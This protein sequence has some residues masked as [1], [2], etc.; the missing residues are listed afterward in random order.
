MSKRTV[1]IQVA[2]SNP[3]NEYGV[4]SFP[5]KAPMVGQE[6]VHRHLETAI[7]NFQ[8]NEGSSAWF[9]VLTSTWGGGKTRTADEIVGQ[10]TGESKGWIDRTGAPLPAIVQPDFADGVL[11]V[12][13]SYK[14]AIKQVEEAGR[15]LPFTAWI[16]RVALAALIGLR[17]KASPQLKSVIEHLE[18]FKAP[19]ARAIRNLPRLADVSRSTPLMVG[20]SLDPSN[21]TGRTFS[22]EAEAVQSVI[23]AMKAN[24]LNRLLVIVE[25]VE[26]PS[27]IR[28]KPG[29][30]LG[31]EAY[32]EIKDTY[33]DVIPEVL[34]SD[35]ERQRFPNVGFLML[36]SPAVYSTIEKIPSQVRRHYAVPIG[37]NTVADLCGYLA[38]L[39]SHDSTIPAYSE[40]LI[41][42]AY[43][44]VDRNMGWM[45]VIMYSRHR[46]WVEGENDPV[47]LLREFAMAD[48]RGKEV[49]VE[50]G[51]DRITGARTDGI[52]QKLLFGQTPVALADIAP[53]DMRRLLTMKVLDATT[54]KAFVELHPLRVGLSELL[55]TALSE[56]G[57][58]VIS[59]GG[60]L[61]LAGDLKVDLARVLDDLA[62]YKTD[63]AGRPVVPRDRDQFILHVTAL[64]GISQTGAAAQ[65]L[66]P[67]FARHIAETATHFGPSFAALRQLDKRLQREDAQFRLLDEE[68]QERMLN[69][70]FAGLSGTDRLRSFVRGFLNLLEEHKSIQEN[71]A[72]DQAVTC[73]VEL[74][75]TDALLLGQDSKIWIVAGKKGSSVRD[76]LLSLGADDKPVRPILLLLSTD[77]PSQRELIDQF[78]Q[79]RPAIAERVFQFPLAEVDERL[80]FLKSESLSEAELTSLAGSLLYRLTERIKQALN[81]RFE[82]L[83]NCG[84]VVW[85]LFRSPGW[86]PYAHHLAEIWLFLAADSNHTLNDAE[87]RFGQTF[88]ENAKAAL[89]ENRPT[90]KKET[91]HLVDHDATPPTPQ[92]SSGLARLVSLMK[93]GGRSVEYLTRRF[94]GASAKPRD[95]VEQMLEWLVN[96]GLVV[97]ASG[98]SSVRIPT[99]SEVENAAEAARTWHDNDLVR[100]LEDLSRYTGIQQELK[101]GGDELKAKLNDLIKTKRLETF[102]TMGD[103][104]AIAPDDGS[105]RADSLRPCWSALGTY[106][107]FQHREMATN[108]AA[109]GEALAADAQQL[110]EHIRN[111]DIPF[112]DR[113]DALG[114][115]VKKL[116]TRVTLL[117]SQIG[118]AKGEYKAKLDAAGLPSLVFDTP[119]D[120]L[121][122]LT[123]REQG[124]SK[125]TKGIM[126][127]E[128]LIHQ[129][130]SKNL[131]KAEQCVE[132][133]EQRLASLK[134]DCDGWI[135]RW[136]VVKSDVTT[137]EQQFNSFKEQVGDLAQNPADGMFVRNHLQE[138]QRLLKPHMDYAE[139]VL[140][141][142]QDLVQTD[143]AEQVRSKDQG[144]A[145][146]DAAGKPVLLQEALKL[147]SGLESGPQVSISRLQELLDPLASQKAAYATVLMNEK[148][149]PND[150]GLG[151]LRF[152]MARLDEGA[153]LVA[154]QRLDSAAALRSLVEEAFRLREEWRTSGPARL[155]DAELFN[156]FL[157]VIEQTNLGNGSIPPATDWEKLGKLKDMNLLT[158]KLT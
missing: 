41:R 147:I 149:S 54:A 153:S 38:H 59:G 112:R 61:V 53:D 25:E 43:L 26:D 143:Y 48:P 155:G 116:E 20:E 120:S 27:E 118:A 69:Q 117:H 83:V 57:V 130:V 1:T 96:L 103:T 105:A 136:V 17:D 108:K 30:V 154:Q 86:K 99:R 65:Y 85:P 156:F 98:D 126:A 52:A 6:Q 70:T 3:W 56:A 67:V 150:P 157:N 18:T 132:T 91:T 145:P 16:P 123:N 58:Q 36:C 122:V 148:G 50:N 151:L 23:A 33:L 133:A 79:N 92:W 106:Q 46:R 71:S 75:R 49:F 2:A 10:V 107:D 34:K 21:P 40:E 78:L 37:R 9:C 80:L 72:D 88:V 4:S 55:E 109:R 128:T 42:A 13:V 90:A 82:D 114:A 144:G 5:P 11:P 89:D 32:Q 31:Q 125:T 47:S 146:F 28:N 8:P 137:L 63:E 131:K 113:A 142:L 81:E 158:L 24:G 73:S 62:A 29:G 134:A 12:M 94:F 119:A 104:L 19:V 35:T 60:A 22:D 39:R 87:A 100:H 14:W 111:K 97:R 135:R 141:G 7:K 44:A 45:N 68:E 15:K 121:L 152:A 77:D 101:A 51:L 95:I 102:H 140:E 64:H 74:E 127:A 76:V 124:I 93:E 84:V 110:E 115:F 66:Y 129:L 138:L 139:E